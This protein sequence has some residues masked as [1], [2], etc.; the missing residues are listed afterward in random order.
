MK[1][2]GDGD[3]DLDVIVVQPLMVPEQAAIENVVQLR[4]SLF[5]FQKKEVPGWTHIPPCLNVQVT[6]VFGIRVTWK[7]SRHDEDPGF[8]V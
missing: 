6:R 3:G 1:V 8:G 4:V 2:S 7:R 5:D